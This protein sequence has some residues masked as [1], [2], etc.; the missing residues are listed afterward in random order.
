MHAD[1]KLENILYLEVIIYLIQ[2]VVKLCDFGF[3]HI[4]NPLSEGHLDHQL[5]HPNKENQTS[6]DI[7]GTLE[8]LDPEYVQG[9]KS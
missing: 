5:S 4:S 2:G 9:R 1:I 3:A 8:Y 6:K 7:V